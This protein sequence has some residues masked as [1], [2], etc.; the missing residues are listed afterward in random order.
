MYLVLY[1]VESIASIVRLLDGTVYLGV[2]IQLGSVG[3]NSAGMWG[4]NIQNSVNGMGRGKKIALV[5]ESP[6][7]HKGKVDH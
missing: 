6:I 3:V 2:H 4:Q 1:T 5:L 7:T